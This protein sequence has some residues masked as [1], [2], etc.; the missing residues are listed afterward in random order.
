MN[1]DMILRA[2]R[3]AAVAHNGQMRKWV[4]LNADPYISHPMRVAGLVALSLQATSAMVAAAWLDTTTLTLIIETP[5]RLKIGIV[6]AF[7]LLCRVFQVE[8]RTWDDMV[9]MPAFVSVVI[10][11]HTCLEKGFKVT[12]EFFKGATEEFQGSLGFIN[13]YQRFAYACSQIYR[14]AKT[15]ITMEKFT[16]CNVGFLAG[17]RGISAN[18]VC[19][20]NLSLIGFVSFFVSFLDCNSSLFCIVKITTFLNFL[21]SVFQIPSS[22]NLFLATST[23]TMNAKSAVFTLIELV[24]RLIQFASSTFLFHKRIIP[25]A[26]TL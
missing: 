14:Q 3:L 11:S 21:F 6:K 26:M 2:A 12:F 24:Q 20:Q 18:S 17:I 4:H 8:R 10:P 9:Y 13:S 25:N 23:M 22:F 19:F 7:S 5:Q 1:D 16:P 15:H